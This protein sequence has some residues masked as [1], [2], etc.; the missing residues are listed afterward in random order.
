MFG[1]L[2]CVVFEL[3]ILFTAYDS[4]WNIANP[5]KHYETTIEQRIM[6]Y[7]ARKFLLLTTLGFISIFG[8]TLYVA[9]SKQ[10]SSQ[11]IFK[12]ENSIN[13]VNKK[14]SLK[15]AKTV[16]HSERKS[17]QLQQPL[18]NVLSNSEIIQSGAKVKNILCN[19]NG[20]YKVNCVKLINAKETQVYIPFSFIH[21]YFEI[22]GKI[23]RS[24]SG[25]KNEEYF[26]WSH[27]SS[28][29]FYPDQ[30]YDSN[31]KFLWFEN[32]DVATRERVKCISPFENVPIST[33]WFVKGHF[34]PTQIAQYGLSHFSKNLTD[35]VQPKFMSLIENGV[36]DKNFV[37]DTLS[38]LTQFTNQNI[39]HVQ[40]NTVLW[41]T[42][43]KPNYLII[44]FE[45]NIKS[46]QASI[47]FYIEDTNGREFCTKYLT[48]DF[49]ISVD[50][51]S[52]RLVTYGIGRNRV[53]SGWFQNTRDLFVDLFNSHL[54]RNRKR[55]E[56]RLVRIELQ[57]QMEIRHLRLADS[58]HDRFS[59][60]AGDWLVKNQNLIGAW[61]IKVKRRL[62]K[63]SASPLIL[64]EGWHSAMAQG[65]AMSLLTRLY[66]VTGEQKYLN[67]ARNALQIFDIESFK[68]GIRTMFLDKYVWFEEYPTVPSIFVLNGFMYS[69]FGLYDL[70]KSCQDS[71]CTKAGQLF[72]DG[73][74]SLEAILPMFDSGS[75]S[76]YDLRHISLAS[77]PNLARW[78]YHATHINQLLQLYT[79][80]RRD[81]FQQ[82]AERWI[83]YMNGH[84]TAHN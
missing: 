80:V 75:G 55:N 3:G 74:H 47:L 35:P 78:D 11:P 79:I 54:I 17:K 73:I 61:D 76:F 5:S 69:L 26:E 51:I 48:E 60:D 37:N 59:R 46:N 7:Y 40:N 62:Q 25:S 6:K 27:T 14:D 24:T 65:Q 45:L 12:N 32:Y 77:A 39:F 9:Y 72:D 63:G 67:T 30:P 4:Y 66:H 42:D 16:I 58:A 53:N 41:L 23:I 29:I 70:S 19:I 71:N 43:N 83:G 15:N 31:G 52:K 56:Y 13:F 20:E 34:Y 49:N 28:K 18:N 1:S 68:N 57:G 33:Q 38:E 2:D 64:N 84:R 8:W 50:K 22:N 82:T 10:I 21:K 81:V 44:H 36:I